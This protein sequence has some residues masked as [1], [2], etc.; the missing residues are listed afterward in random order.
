M[1]APYG[2]EHNATKNL[3]DGYLHQYTVDAISNLATAKASD[4]K[5]IA[6]LTSTVARLTTELSTVKNKLVFA[7]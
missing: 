6:Q 2:A 4:R 1:G 5:E 7:L 3:E